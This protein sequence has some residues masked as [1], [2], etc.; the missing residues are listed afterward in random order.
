MHRNIPTGTLPS[1]LLLA[2]AAGAAFP[3]PAAAEVELT[4]TVAYRAGGYDCTGTVLFDGFDLPGFRSAFCEYIRAE[5]Q[6]GPAFG[7]VLGVGLADDLLLEVLASRQETELEID[8][9]PPVEIFFPLSDLDFTVT[10]LQVGVARSWGEGAVRPFAGVAAGASRVQSDGNVRMNGFED[11]AFSA[12]LGAGLKV[13][14]DERFGVRLE[15]RGYWVD[16]PSEAGGDFT[17]TEAA[18][19]LILKF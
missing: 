18:A 8:F 17:Q 9:L 16:L 14:L 4:P 6:D 10:H 12:S 2:I 3:A 13:F 7:A 5:S 19:G 1:I 11:D 15:G